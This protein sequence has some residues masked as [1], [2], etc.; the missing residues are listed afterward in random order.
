MRPARAAGPALI[1]TCV[2]M[3][4]EYGISATLISLSLNIL[5][6]GILFSFG[7]VLTKVLGEAGSAALSKITS[8]LL[9]SI[10]VMMI[11][12]GVMSMVN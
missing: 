9:A 2:L 6:A 8:L 10:A 4:N 12:R 7:H 11:R 1:T 5:I 3:S